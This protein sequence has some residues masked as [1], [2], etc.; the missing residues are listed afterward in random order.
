MGLEWK[1]MGQMG[2]I[3]N[4][5]VPN[6]ASRNYSEFTVPYRYWTEFVRRIRIKRPKSA[7][8]TEKLLVFAGIITG[9]LRVIAIMRRFSR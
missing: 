8:L 5:K 4:R 2:R 1:R 9:S 3:K 7:F 6:P